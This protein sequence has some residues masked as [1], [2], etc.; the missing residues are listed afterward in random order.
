MPKPTHT[1]IAVTRRIA[2]IW[3]AMSAGSSWRSPV[4]PVS[5]TT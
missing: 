3:A 5:D 1:G 2:A 4:T